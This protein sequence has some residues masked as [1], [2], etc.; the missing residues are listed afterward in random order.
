MKKTF[1]A[2]SANIL[3][4]TVETNTPKGGDTGHGGK[5]VITFKDHASTDMRIKSD[6][7]STYNNVEEI[8]LL[9]GGDTEYETLIRCLKFAVYELEKQHYENTITNN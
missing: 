7:D 5:T 8:S 3:S 6:N 1:E 2:T 4:V 9:F